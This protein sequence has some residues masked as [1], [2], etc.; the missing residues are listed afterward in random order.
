MPQIDV[1]ERE[2]RHPQLLTLGAEPRADLKRFIKYLRKAQKVEVTDWAILDLGSGTGRNAN[3]LAT[4][5]NR[6]VGFEVSATALKLARARAQTLGVVV[7]YRQVDIGSTYPLADQSVDLVVDVMS[8]NS[9]N[10]QER[11]IYLAEVYRVLKPNGYFFVRA[12]CK[13][14]D[15]NAKKLLKLSPGPETDTYINT[16]MGL[17]ERVFSEEDFRGAYSALFAI[18]TLSKKTNYA[19]FAGQNY[20]RNYW[21]GVMQKGK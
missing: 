7:D 15:K 19:K 18:I 10:E 8:S 1:W 3:Y 6:V 5:G 11:A 13:D 20:K 4:L 21:V 2:Y 16:D 14:G 17:A 9:L 12:L